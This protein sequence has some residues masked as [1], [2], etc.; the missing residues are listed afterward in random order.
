MQYMQRSSHLLEALLLRID[1][2][3]KILDNRQE[4]IR[5]HKKIVR[6]ED[7]REILKA[8]GGS[9]DRQGAALQWA[10][11]RLE[12]RW[13]SDAGLR[14]HFGRFQISRRR[15]LTMADIEMKHFLQEVD[16][17]NTLQDIKDGYPRGAH[18]SPKS[19]GDFMQ[20]I[21]PA[22]STSSNVQSK[23]KMFE[24]VKEY[25]DSEGPARPPIVPCQ[26]HQQAESGTAS[27]QEG[28]FRGSR[29]L[30]MEMRQT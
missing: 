20:L 3:A 7:E 4:K 28:G 12:A 22:S 1:E 10:A 9:A 27:L 14:Q 19:M 24:V 13:V 5:K 17:I 29:Q 11:R 15:V 21:P 6:F 8:I 25:W 2:S 16:R 23:S 30:Q 18:G 26:V